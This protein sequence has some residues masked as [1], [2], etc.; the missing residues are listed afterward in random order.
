MS[1]LVVLLGIAGLLAVAG[2]VAGELQ[3]E[4]SQG[5]TIFQ[6]MEYLITIGFGATIAA[7]SFGAIA[8]KN[9]VSRVYYVERDNL[10]LLQ[11]LHERAKEAATPRA[12][13]ED[14]K[15]TST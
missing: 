3:L 2:G 15:P 4:Q 5:A 12:P 1:F 14:E 11:L 6:Q 9:M 13:I 7:V 10:R 8:V